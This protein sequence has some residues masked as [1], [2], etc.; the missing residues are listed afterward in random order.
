MMFRI[1]PKGGNV[2]AC[3]ADLNRDG[4]V[5]ITDLSILLYNWGKPKNALADLNH[6]A[7]VNIT[8][9]SILL[10]YWGKCAQ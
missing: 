9:F 8:D 3:F 6:D 1:I 4:K 2:N 5:D 10:Y 7:R